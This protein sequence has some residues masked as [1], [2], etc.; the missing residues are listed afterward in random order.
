[1]RKKYQYVRYKQIKKIT[2]SSRLV[3]MIVTNRTKRT[4]EYEFSF[5][6]FLTNYYCEKE[7]KEETYVRM[8]VTYVCGIALTLLFLK[9]NFS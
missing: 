7:K 3:L 5:C 9:F 6:N 2:N 8:Y 1:M 4:D